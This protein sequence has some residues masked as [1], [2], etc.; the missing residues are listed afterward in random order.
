MI[1]IDKESLDQMSEHELVELRK[2]VYARLDSIA[3]NKRRKA[4]IRKNYKLLPFERLYS[5]D[6]HRIYLDVSN[7]FRKFDMIT[8]DAFYE[9]VNLNKHSEPLTYDNIYTC[10][11]CGQLTLQVCK[12]EGSMYC[13]ECTGCE[14]ESPKRYRGYS[15]YET[16]ELFHEYLIKHKYL[17][18]SVEFPR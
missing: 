7:R 6:Y 14:F 2:E 17:G 10:P 11:M 12:K 13:I 4:E 15:P 18:K 16:W 1:P 5:L 3:E 8:A 9:I